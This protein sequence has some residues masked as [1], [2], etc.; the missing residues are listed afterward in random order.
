M[1]IDQVCIST[2]EVWLSVS[3]IS[4]LPSPRRCHQV[5]RKSYPNKRHYNSQTS[6]R[7]CN[8]PRCRSTRRAAQRGAKFTWHRAQVSMKL[9]FKL[10]TENWVWVLLRRLNVFH[11]FSLRWR[12]IK[13]T[14]TVLLRF[15]EIL[16]FDFISAAGADHRQDSMKL[17]ANWL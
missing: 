16:K 9:I 3:V 11:L 2:G 5:R 6:S 14:F 10:K 1:T 4:W 7:R 15:V 8:P 13:K 12:E 17:A